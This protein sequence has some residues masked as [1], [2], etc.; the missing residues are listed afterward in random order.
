MDGI[1]AYWDGQ[2]LLSRHGKEIE[3]PKEFVLGLPCDIT[4]DGELW[5][6]RSTFEK[7]ISVLNSKSGDW[8]DIKYH[9]FDVPNSRKLHEERMEQI[10]QIHFPQKVQK[11]YK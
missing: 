9:V 4:L 6:G 7:L 8:S 3:V 2:K 10:K 5:I 1:R 11:F